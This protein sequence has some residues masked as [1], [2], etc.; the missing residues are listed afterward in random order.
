MTRPLRFRGEIH[1]PILAYIHID[2][3]VSA[4]TENKRRT[5]YVQEKVGQFERIL[6]RSILHHR[7]VRHGVYEHWR[8]VHVN[9]FD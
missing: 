5:I 6:E 2:L 1:D 3:M 9:N 8:V 7:D 4:P